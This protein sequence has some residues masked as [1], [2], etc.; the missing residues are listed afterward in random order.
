[1]QNAVGANRA[2]FAYRQVMPIDALLVRAYLEGFITTLIT[3]VLGVGG[4]FFGTSLLPSDPL[5]TVVVLFGLWLLGLGY[6]LV[7]SVA[8]ELI[9]KV[10]VVLGIVSTFLM[11]SSGVMLPVNNIPDPYRG[12]LLINPLL[13]GTEAVRHSIS[14]YYH[15]LSGVDVSYIY[16]CAI[17]AV[18]FGLALHRHYQ[19]KLTS[20]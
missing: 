1:M 20:L 12:W 11:L 15:A 19:A 10:S 3:I 17:V 14:P 18:F 5:T 9:P 7:T 4:S 2:L 8:S 13:H 6:G 16:R